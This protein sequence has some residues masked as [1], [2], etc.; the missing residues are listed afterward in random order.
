MQAEGKRSQSVPN[1]KGVCSKVTAKDLGEWPGLEVSFQ[2]PAVGMRARGTQQQGPPQLGLGSEPHWSR[3]R[4]SSVV[5]QT[6]ST[7]N[8][9]SLFHLTATDHPGGKVFPIKL[10]LVMTNSSRIKDIMAASQSFIQA[11][12][13]LL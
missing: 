2:R 1:L 12:T 7:K 4:A 13:A 11:T 6:L 10:H 9:F 3:S 8:C 5:P